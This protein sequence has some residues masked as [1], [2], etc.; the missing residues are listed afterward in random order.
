MFSSF[1]TLA[2]ATGG[3]CDFVAPGEAVAPAVLRMFARLR[4]PRLTDLRLIWP[5]DA[6]PQ[7]VSSLLPSVFDG[8]TVNVFALLD[9]VAAGT[10]RLM[11][12]RA[13]DAVAQE[14]GRATFEG[15]L[16]AGDTLPRMA[17]SVRILSAGNHS[18]VEGEYDVTQCAVAYRLVT[19]Q[20]NFLLIHERPDGQ[21]TT[22]M[23]QLHKVDQ[24]VAAGWGGAGSVVSS[25]SR[26]GVGTPHV[27]HHVSE[28][29]SNY[30]DDYDVSAEV[31]MP[32]VFR[33]AVTSSRM[34]SVN[35]R[36][37]VFLR[38]DDQSIDDQ[39]P[40]DWSDTAHYTGL[41][42][43]GLRLRLRQTPNVEWPSTY[44][45]LRQIGLGVALVD[46]L[47]LSMAAHGGT[48]HAES[49]VVGAFL[50]LMSRRDTSDTPDGLANP[51]GLFE[52][53]KSTVQRLRGILADGPVAQ[54][55][56][57]DVA[58]FEAMALVLSGMTDSDWPGS[59]L[60]SGDVAGEADE[61]LD[62]A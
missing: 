41:T 2:E 46:W 29:R 31:A 13:E 34:A 52:A 30:D 47:E 19:D 49:T 16:Q 58:L 15:A 59:V 44:R 32:A 39:V 22:D 56:G 25:R 57:L 37:P 18:P 24:M 23:P 8:D 11:G 7:W 50:Y 17:A 61:A 51:T 12:K 62:V 26:S 38:S 43:V 36:L 5:D 45:G 54:F 53:F 21:K 40:T 20:T 28:G 27:V 4:S 6:V 60:A 33:R 10:V 9:G 48:A 42:P 1:M 35:T 14:I 3:A 55:A